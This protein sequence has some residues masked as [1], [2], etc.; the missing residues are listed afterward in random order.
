LLGIGAAWFEAEHVALGFEFPPLRVR[1]EHLVDALE[2]CRGMFTQHAT[3]Y[4]GTHHAA[5]DAFNSPGPI[6]AIPIL[7]GGQGERKTFRIAA[8]YADEL[9]TTA[10]FND[11]P[12]KLDALQGHLD[13]L[14]RNRS[15]ITVTPLG[16]LVLAETHD[17]A[18]DKLKALLNARG[19]DAN[20]LLADEA[21]TRQLLGRFVWG[22]PG[23]VIAR[24]RELIALGLD[25]VVFNMV[26][27]ADDVDAI[28]L[29]GETLTKA[30]G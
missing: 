24:V 22:D 14:G 30:L 23:E 12:R 10:D 16:S 20:A 2:I 5:N 4:V 21:G 8:Q 29:A 17:A 13:D 25:G 28:A 26:A 6:G 15:D 9:N 7:I 18:V 19:F 3:T 27:D 11:L 1:Y